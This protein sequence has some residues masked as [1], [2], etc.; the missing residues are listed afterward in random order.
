LR[1]LLSDLRRIENE[2]ERTRILGLFHELQ[3]N[4]TLRRRDRLTTGEPA[5][6]GVEQRGC[7]LPFTIRAEAV[8]GL[9]ELPFG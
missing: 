3:V 7:K 4:K 5:S 8:D 1:N 2:L 6:T 9:E